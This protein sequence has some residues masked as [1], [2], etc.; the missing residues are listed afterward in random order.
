MSE[1]GAITRIQLR[2]DS[3]DDILVDVNVGPHTEYEEIP[4]RTPADDVWFVPSVGEGV[5]V[6]EYGRGQYIAH[7][8]VSPES[9]LP[10]EAEEGDIVISKDSGTTII[11]ADDGSITIN[12]SGDIDLNADNLFYD[13]DRLATE[14]HTHDY[15]DSTINDTDDGSGTESTTTKTTDSPDGSGL[16]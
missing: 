4:F 11:I 8:P 7:S 9:E 1:L 15:D 16:T 13:G 6:S 3:R 12:A 10:A 14:N 5:E 2:P